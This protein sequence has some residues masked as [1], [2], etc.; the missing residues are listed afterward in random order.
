MPLPVA[1]LPRMAAPM[2]DRA[3]EAGAQRLPA[4][5][6]SRRLWPLRG[7]R[8]SRARGGPPAQPATTLPDVGVVPQCLLT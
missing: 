5:R 8:V 6:M 1:Q 3:F 7:Q 2:A 4:G